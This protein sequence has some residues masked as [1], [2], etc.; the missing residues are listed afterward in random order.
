MKKLNKDQKNVLEAV[1]SY[2]GVDSQIEMVVEECA[3]LIDAIKKYKRGRYSEESVIEEMAD[4]YIMLN[5]LEIIFTNCERC[6]YDEVFDKYLSMKIDRISKIIKFKNHNMK[7]IIKNLS[8]TAQNY[9]DG[10]FYV[11]RDENVDDELMNTQIIVDAWLS[12]HP[13]DKNI[14]PW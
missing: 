5:Q 14:L 13:Y 9:G 7:E 4:V 12:V 10:D 2:Y 8:E 11:W 6:K 3:E 1:I